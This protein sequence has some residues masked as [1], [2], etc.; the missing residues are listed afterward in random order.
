MST[1]NHLK[2]N[3]KHGIHQHYKGGFYRALMLV[4]HHETEEL[5]VVYLSL[6]NGSLRLRELATP[7]KDSWLDMIPMMQPRFDILGIPMVPAPDAPR[8]KH[9]TD[10]QYAEFQLLKVGAQYA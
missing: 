8:F 10:E 1:Q 4:S 7:G 6:K 9:F 5:F 3:F 2:E